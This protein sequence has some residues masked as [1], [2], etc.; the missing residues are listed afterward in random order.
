MAENQAR[1]DELEQKI[2]EQREKSASA[3]RALYKMQHE[4]YSLISAVVEAGSF[5]EF[6]ERISYMNYIQNR[7]IQTILELSAMQEELAATQAELDEQR[8]EAQKEQDAAKE[9]LDEAMAIR[10]QMIDEA[11]AQAAA[12][13]EAQA[14]AEAQS[15][16]AESGVETSAPAVDPV[17]SGNTD[18]DSFVAEWA[19]RI[20]AYMAG[21]PLAGYGAV[22]AGAA[23]AYGVDP[24]FSPAISWVESSKGL[25]CYRS[26]NAWGWGGISWDSWEEAIDAHVRGLARGYGYTVTEAGAKKYCPPNWEH[27]YNTV[28]AEMA[29][30]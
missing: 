22:F 2:P 9:A 13:A 30:I 25:Y 16:E 20:D 12:E 17:N 3:I 21:Y 18:R 8:Q 6:L 29:K 28:G 7:N 15:G 5:K 27:W 24:R 23:W 4:G 11:A 19:P 1:I 14:Q 26:H 10:Q